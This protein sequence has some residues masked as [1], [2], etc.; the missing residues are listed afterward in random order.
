VADP[1]HPAAKAGRFVRAVGLGI[2]RELEKRAD[3]PPKAKPEPLPPPPPVRT[4]GIVGTAVF[5]AFIV[6]LVAGLLSLLKADTLAAHGTPRLVFRLTLGGV[7][8][9]VA[10]LL[11]TNWHLANQR[12]GQRV[13]TRIWGPRG[14]MNKRERFIARRVRDV[15]MLVGIGFLAGAVYEILTAFVGTE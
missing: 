6:G 8:L 12:L 14:A 1:K 4:G 10:L 5:Y 9:A 2:A 11:E 13:L 15:L 3:A 7:M